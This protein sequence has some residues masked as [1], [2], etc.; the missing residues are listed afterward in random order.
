LSTVN[1][2]SFENDKLGVQISAE[3]PQLCYPINFHLHRLARLFYK[4]QMEI[5]VCT[6]AER[7]FTRPRK[8][9]SEI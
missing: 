9:C 2:A 6:N 7:E 1:G 3:I 5:Q 8:W 4:N